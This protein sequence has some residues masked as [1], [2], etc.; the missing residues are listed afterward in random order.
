MAKTTLMK[1]DEGS[2]LPGHIPM[3]IIPTFLVGSD[4]HFLPLTK[5]VM[6]QSVEA[7]FDIES[8]SCSPSSTVLTRICLVHPG[9]TV[10][11][12]EVHMF[13]EPIWAGV[14]TCVRWTIE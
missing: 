2:Q 8:T 13:A 9:F 1:D 3:T 7:L 4:G 6:P 10:S 12:L 5:E 14:S 11:V